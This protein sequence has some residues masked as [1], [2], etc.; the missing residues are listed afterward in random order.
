[1]C[2][3]LQLKACPSKNDFI[4]FGVK[5]INML[6]NI[7]GSVLNNEEFIIISITI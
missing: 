4:Y 2:S 6:L 5:K 1:M 7:Q 3:K